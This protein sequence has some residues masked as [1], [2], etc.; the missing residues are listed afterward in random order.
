MTTEHS[1]NIQRRPEKKLIQQKAIFP[2]F[3]SHE[4]AQKV[5]KKQI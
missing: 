4:E 5:T 3:F 1:I 2:D